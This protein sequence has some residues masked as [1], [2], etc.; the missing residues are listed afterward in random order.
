MKI[1]EQLNS[2]FTKLNEEYIDLDN[3]NDFE[4]LAYQLDANY[5]RMDEIQERMAEIANQLEK[6]S[7]N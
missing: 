3:K 5:E 6:L 1:A 7:S 4:T 2:E